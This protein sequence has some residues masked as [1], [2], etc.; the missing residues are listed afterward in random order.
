MSLPHFLY[1]DEKY[2]NAVEGLEPDEEKHAI[3]L[4]LEP[5]SIVCLT[6][7]PFYFVINIM[8]F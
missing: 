4:H 2:L 1:A 5:V 3:Y 7:V 8:N 6:P